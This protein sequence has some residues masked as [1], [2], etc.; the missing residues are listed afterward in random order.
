MII[1][2]NYLRTPNSHIFSRIF[3]IEDIRSKKKDRHKHITDTKVKKNSKIPKVVLAVF[4]IS[5]ISIKYE[6]SDP[7]YALKLY[8]NYFIPLAMI[9]RLKMLRPEASLT[10]IFILGTP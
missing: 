5:S 7:K 2:A 4:S 6:L 9:S 1:A 3:D 10:N 8:L